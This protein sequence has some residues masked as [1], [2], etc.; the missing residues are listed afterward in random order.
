MCRYQPFSRITLTVVQVPRRILKEGAILNF[1]TL[2]NRDNKLI[3][4]SNFSIITSANVVFIAGF[5]H[6][7]YYT[8]SFE[9]QLL[10][11][12]G[13]KFVQL[14]SERRDSKGSLSNSI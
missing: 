12:N 1:F 13:W 10:N 5:A 14:K 6:R 11:D 8:T 4:L 9:Y 3:R 2:L 7:Q